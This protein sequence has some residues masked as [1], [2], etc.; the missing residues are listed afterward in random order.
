MLAKNWVQL[1][2]QGPLNGDVLTQVA[3]LLV[4][5]GVAGDLPHVRVI[6]PLYANVS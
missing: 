3:T 5:R 6:S 4:G 2:G 1:Y